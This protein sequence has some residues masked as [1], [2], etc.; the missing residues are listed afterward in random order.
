[1]DKEGIV[2][3]AYFTVTLFSSSSSNLPLGSMLL[4][5]LENQLVPLKTPVPGAEAEVVPL[6][7]DV[8]L[9]LECTFSYMHNTHEDDG[10]E[11]QPIEEQDDDFL[12]SL[13][14]PGDE[15]EEEVC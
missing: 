2:S 6:T 14:G 1:M 12:S 9:L 4:Q 13:I 10:Q 5:D 15:E 11:K 3:P 8:D 7:P